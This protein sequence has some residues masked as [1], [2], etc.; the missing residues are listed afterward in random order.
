MW[1]GELR[2]SLLHDRRLW[3]ALTPTPDHAKKVPLT[4]RRYVDYVDKYV[5][6]V[7]ARTNFLLPSWSTA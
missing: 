1:G 3:I 7:L 6:R 2:F 5:A 4:V